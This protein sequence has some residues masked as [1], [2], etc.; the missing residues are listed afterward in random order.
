MNSSHP[1]GSTIYRLDYRDQSLVYATDFE[2]KKER[3]EELTRFSE[4]CDLLIYDG[5]Y[6][7]SEYKTWEGYGHSTMQIGLSI[8]RESG[9]KRLLITHHDPRH[10][11]A[12]LAEQDRLLQEAC[13]DACFA[14]PMQV[15]DLQE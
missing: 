8:M 9:A 1:G 10:K 2:H 15:F 5:Q 13:P 12:F 6:T 11:D 7:E 4:G 14:R 3:A